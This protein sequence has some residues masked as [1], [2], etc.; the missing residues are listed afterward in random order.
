MDSVSCESANKRD[1]L[2]FLEYLRFGMEAIGLI[3][4][5]IYTAYTIRM[6][7]ANKQAADAATSASPSRGDSGTVTHRSLPPHRP[8]RAGFPQR[9]PQVDSL[10]YPGVHNPRRQQRVPS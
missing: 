5:V 7:A 2:E 6:F 10:L 3:A 4:L 1:I 8:R 9:V